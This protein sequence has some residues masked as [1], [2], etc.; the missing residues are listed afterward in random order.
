MLG[1]EHPSGPVPH[2]LP[3]SHTAATGNLPL[4]G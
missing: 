2:M 1:A 4:Q 3:V